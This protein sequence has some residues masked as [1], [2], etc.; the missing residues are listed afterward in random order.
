L[1]SAKRLALRWRIAIHTSASGSRDKEL[2]ASEIVEPD[3]AVGG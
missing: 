1:L 2:E 3:S